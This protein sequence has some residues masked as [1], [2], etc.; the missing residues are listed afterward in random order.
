MEGEQPSPLARVLVAADSGNG[1]SME[2]S[3]ETHVFINTELTVHLHREP[4]GEWVCLDART[5]IGPDGAGV[6]T[7]TLYDSVGRFGDRQPGPAGSAALS[8]RRDRG[9]RSR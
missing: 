2:L 1:V 3:L 6:A 5:R 8:R 4:V 7:S 9:R